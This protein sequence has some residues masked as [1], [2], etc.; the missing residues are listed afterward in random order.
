MHDRGTIKVRFSSRLKRPHVQPTTFGVPLARGF[1][2]DAD[3]IEIRDADD[4]RTPAQCEPLASWPDGSIRWLLVDAVVSFGAD[5]R[6]KI[7]LQRVAAR[8]TSSSPPSTSPVRTSPVSTTE[9]PDESDAVIAPVNCSS[10]GAD[11][12]CS[13]ARAPETSPSDG[14]PDIRWVCELGLPGGVTR[15]LRVAELRR[16]SSGPVRETI[17]GR[18]SFDVDGSISLDALF[19]IHRYPSVGVV[20]VD[21][22]VRNPQAA[23]HPGGLWD[24]GDAGSVSFERL[25]LVG[26]LF[27]EPTRLAWTTEVQ[28][29]EFSE[30]TSRLRIYQDSSGGDAWLSPNHVD[31]NGD[32]TVSF[33]GFRVEHAGSVD[34]GLRADPVVCA[35]GEES[36]LSAAMPRFWEEFPSAVEIDGQRLSI[37]YLPARTGR[38]HELQGGEQKTFSAYVSLRGSSSTVADL[39]WVHAPAASTLDPKHCAATGVLRHFSATEPNEEFRAMAQLALDGKRSFF[40]KRETID[41]YGWRNF[42]DVYADHEIDHYEGEEPL[43]SHYNNQYDLV[44]SWLIQHLRTG[45]SRWHRLAADLAHHVVDIDLYHTTDDR[46]AYSLGYFWHTDHYCTAARATHRCYSADNAPEGSSG[47]Y[48]GGPSNEH[49]YTSGLLLFHYLSGDPRAREAVLDLADWVVQMDDGQRSLFGQIEEGPTGLAS[50]TYCSDFHGPGRGAG[51]SVNALLDAYDLTGERRYLAKAEELIARCVHPDDDVAALE[52]DDPERRWSYLVFLQVLARYLDD[53]LRAG[54]EDRA[55]RYAR[56]CFVRYV[57]WM[58]EHEVPYASVFDRVE[59]PT[60]TWPAHDLRKSV[61]FGDALRFGRPE[62]RAR[63]L[64]RSE[65]FYEAAFQGMRQFS[66][67]D[68]A[69]PLAL[70]LANG[71][72]REYLESSA[73]AESVGSPPDERFDPPREFVPLRE[74]ARR[75]LRTP[76]GALRLGVAL[77]RPR[78][79]G[80]ILRREIW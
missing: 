33:R 8:P 69:R 61:I 62:H 16:T 65:S 78:T 30:E 12:E 18:G 57:D 58:L 19:R 44:H 59:F 3:A 32:S 23:E 1:L 67:F 52:L 79:I 28:G 11:F 42:G 68:T 2:R 56:L 20:K 54:D 75:A 35:I 34:E 76:R 22:T 7:T 74:R 37:E 31:A 36:G 17:E 39:A 46:P 53:K 49:N 47:G 77:L 14:A 55:Y 41:E 4:H 38:L 27:F 45:D 43:V 25:A 5:G 26:E 24:L 66:G 9:A 63:Y 60:V 10:E 21:L 13:I 51:N 72:Q 48:G 15:P 29:G 71:F 50:K 73:A 70:V 64:E 40:E 80:R 6:G